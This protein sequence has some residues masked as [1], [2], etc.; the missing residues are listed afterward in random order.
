MRKQ[1]DSPVSAIT[2]HGHHGRSFSQ[3]LGNLCSGND[4][5]GTRRTDVE[6]LLIKQ[7]I[8]H[9][10]RLLI[11]DM[12]RAIQ[13]LQVGRQVGRQPALSN[14]LGDRSGPLAFRF[15]RLDELVQHAPRRIGEVT[16]DASVGDLLQVPN[17][18][19]EGTACPG[20]TCKRVNLAVSLTPDFG[21]GRLDV[22][23]PVGRVVELVGPHGVFEGFG[24]PFCLVVVVLGVV[25][26]DGWRKTR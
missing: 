17:G 1:C 25:K 22:G 18:A 24:V 8:H 20:R 12:Q 7:P 23:F 11:R 9:L 16:L 14:T 5:Q 2:Q 21:T 15:T 3:P 4:I 6:P 19:R 10:D 26:G 13:Q